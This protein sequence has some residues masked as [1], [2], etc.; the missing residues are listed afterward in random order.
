MSTQTAHKCLPEFFS[1]KGPIHTTITPLDFGNSIYWMATV[2]EESKDLEDRPYQLKPYEDNEEGVLD[3][4]DI[5]EN[6]D[7]VLTKSGKFTTSFYVPNSLVPYII[8]AKGIKL[9]NLQKTT[10]T[11]IKIPKMNEKGEV[12]ITGDTER[13]VASARNQ[14]A[15]IVMQRKDRLPISHFISIPMTSDEVTENLN[16]F[17]EKIL[18]NPPTGVTPSLFQKPHKLHLTICTLTLVDDEEIAAAKKVLQTCYEEVI[19]KEFPK[20]QQYQ[21]VVQGVEIMND[22]P[23]EVNVLYG[24]V[25]MKNPVQNERLQ[26]ISDTI[27]EY[28]YRSGLAKKQYD[29]VKL[30]VTLMNTSFRNADEKQEKFDATDIVERYPNYRF[31]VV[32][33]NSIHLSIRFTGGGDS[34][35]ESAL[36]LDI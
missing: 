27:S 32:D 15:M 36:V 7:I 35:Y 21:V 11:L 4:G 34:Y 17:R 16:K 22:D 6:Y 5:D 19:C 26:G 25:H 2:S 8:G 33:F 10:N 13:R 29:R 3:C 30:H 12:K 23:S 9:R 31:G 28:F 24:K 20:N 18:E 1:T 14:I